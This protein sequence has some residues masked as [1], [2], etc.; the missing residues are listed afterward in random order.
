MMGC[1]RFIQGYKETEKNFG[2]IVF[3]GNHPFKQKM[4]DT[5]F[6]IEMRL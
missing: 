2:S 5:R 6:Y 4:P 3:S 1:W